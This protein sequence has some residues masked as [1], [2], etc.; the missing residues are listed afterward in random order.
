MSV[1]L[2]ERLFIAIREGATLC[3]GSKLRFLRGR[4]LTA[5]DPGCV[6]TRAPS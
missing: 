6:K 2:K 4:W 5:S 1:D 3:S